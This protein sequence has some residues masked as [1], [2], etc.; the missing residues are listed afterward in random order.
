[1]RNAKKFVAGLDNAQNW[2]VFLAGDF[3]SL[4]FDAPY[5]C[6]TKSGQGRITER[7]T[8]VLT[9]SAIHEYKKKAALDEEAEVEEDE[10]Q[11]EVTAE[12]P[13]ASEIAELIQTTTASQPIVSE[14]IMMEE[15]LPDTS[16]PPVPVPSADSA[17]RIAAIEDIYKLHDNNK[18]LLRSVYGQCYRFVHSENANIESRNGEAAFSN[19]AHTWR[20]LLD[21]IFVFDF[22]ER[23][24]NDTVLNSEQGDVVPGVK[25]LELLRLPIPAE[26]GEEPSGQPRAGQYPSDHLCLMVKLRIT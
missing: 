20:G 23:H 6:L 5:L 12:I 7:S 10:E 24:N 22:P 16:H 25:V 9:N 21:Y 17:S 15:F 18:A 19:W 26:M 8:Y 13:E 14:P 3:N 11:E 2:P 4:P 1:M